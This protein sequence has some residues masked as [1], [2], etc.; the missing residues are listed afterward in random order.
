CKVFRDTEAELLTECQTETAL[1]DCWIQRS[2]CFRHVIADSPVTQTTD[3]EVQRQAFVNEY[4]YHWS[5]ATLE[6]IVVII[7]IKNSFNDAVRSI[8]NSPCFVF[9][10]ILT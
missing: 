2:W 4:L 5:D 1:V 8:I 3:T 6:T 7:T 10:N 9:R